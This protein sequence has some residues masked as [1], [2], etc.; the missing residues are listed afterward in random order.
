MN[1]K[2]V[3]L[4]ALEQLRTALVER[5]D[6][7]GVRAPISGSALAKRILD[8]GMVEAPESEEFERLIQP[9]NTVCAALFRLRGDGIDGYLFELPL[10]IAEISGKK[11]LVKGSEAPVVNQALREAVLSK[12]EVDIFPIRPFI[13]PFN[14]LADTKE[15]LRV[16]NLKI[17]DEAVF[18]PPL[19]HEY[20][21]LY[22]KDFEKL[23]PLIRTQGENSSIPVRLKMVKAN[24][25][26]FATAF[27]QLVNQRCSQAVA[28]YGRFRDMFVFELL[29]W[30]LSEGQSVLIA[31]PDKESVSKIVSYIKNLGFEDV[32]PERF[33]GDA[34]F[35]LDREAKNI[36]GR[37][38]HSP[39]SERMK[40][41]DR[42]L[43]MMDDYLGSSTVQAGLG[44]IETGE[45]ALTGLNKFSYYRSLRRTSFNLDTSFYS[46]EEFSKDKAFFNSVS[47]IPFVHLKS[48]RENPM[49]SYRASGSSLQV[50]QALMATL[51]KT[52]KDLNSLQKK[53]DESRISECTET[54]IESISDYAEI[55]ATVST[56]LRYDG[57]T[58]QFFDFAK[59]EKAVPLALRLS[60]QKQS[61]DQLFEEL[62]E[63]V[64]DVNSLAKIPYSKYL[65]DLKSKSFRVRR[66][67][68]KQIE[69]TLRE[70]DDFE[71]FV[72]N[73]REYVEETATLEKT[74]A[75][76]EE[77]F[78]L[79]LYS[80][81]GPERI[82]SSLEFVSDYENIVRKNPFLDRETNPFISRIFQDREFRENE[83]DLLRE[84]DYAVDTLESDA[85]NI[86]DFFSD[87]IVSDEIP[88]DEM[89]RRLRFRSTTHPD[90]FRQYMVY[91]SDVDKASYTVKQG[92]E[93]YDS[94]S[95]TFQTFENDYWYSLYKSLAFN[96]YK[97]GVSD[98]YPALAAMKGSLSTLRESRNFETFRSVQSRA[99]AAWWDSEDGKR[100]RVT[101]RMA[102]HAK[103]YQI[104][105]N[106]WDLASKVC[107]LQV[108]SL[109]TYPL[110]SKAKYD[111]VIILD[112]GRFGDLDLTWAVTRGDS[113][114]AVTES[115]D[116][117][118]SGYP[119]API[120]LKTL[121]RGPL[122]YSLL[123]DDFMNLLA[124]GFDENGYE[125][126]TAEES[127][128]DMPFSYV[129]K[130]G[131][132]RCVI[133]YSLIG[134]RQVRMTV[135]GADAALMAL[136]L[137][138]L[139]LFPSMPLVV[140]PAGVVSSVD[141][142]AERFDR[143]GYADDL[144]NLESDNKATF[145]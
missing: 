44:T 88:F 84:V 57:F 83:R 119:K 23:E 28:P 134:P 24:I 129:G 15:A 66:R 43:K 95:Y 55:R 65:E 143:G 135:V 117:R 2:R 52:L 79:I 58:L 11:F 70:K 41:A 1:L 77:K 32:F 138:P 19:Q 112:P 90:E 33:F 101:L 97:G 42:A 106:Y 73:L 116:S 47:K 145:K 104:L 10:R 51:D 122:D 125:L 63:F 133:P 82:L 34:G 109:D 17:S 20:I 21:R 8:G 94:Q 45:D 3:L 75:E 76:A 60:S 46:P 37:E 86:A 121:Y 53:L 48:I 26:P 61:A 93:A 80:E 68:K 4:E 71:A 16:S 87:P 81:N 111:L 7:I 115:E 96:R 141:E 40:R 9:D 139:T 98:P 108:S 102:P 13:N 128:S 36:S 35:S 107:P 30:A 67:A 120:D 91:L 27:Q 5:G 62:C 78:G 131:V 38:G 12:I 6:G 132:R 69:S 118:L 92:L 99:R 103:S 113:A 140:D 127:G 50:Y 124:F 126:E 18:E 54:P 85:S 59:D 22:R 136:G 123:S 130:D 31:A 39:D 110:T 49:H 105:D 89:E 114:I 29:N 72:Q 74:M 64:K 144:G 142:N 56:I 14:V 25:F 137:S 100:C